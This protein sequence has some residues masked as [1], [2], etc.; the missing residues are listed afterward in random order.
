MNR[1]SCEFNLSLAQCHYECGVN[2]IT[3]LQ[4]LSKPW[5]Q[6]SSTLSRRYHEKQERD[7]QSALLKDVHMVFQATP[8]LRWVSV[9]LKLF[10]ANGA[11]RW[12]TE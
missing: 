4:D 12:L 8:Y 1:A 5:Q 11:A 7:M 2:A 3:A 6:E 9:K 10:R